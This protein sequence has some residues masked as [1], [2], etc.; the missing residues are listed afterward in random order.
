M[1]GAL[2]LMSSTAPS[3]LAHANPDCW[4]VC[5]S[6]DGAG[7]VRPPHRLHDQ[8]G[9]IIDHQHVHREETDQ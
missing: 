9:E 6:E 3:L 2:V 4:F 1:V 5:R 7:P 8:T